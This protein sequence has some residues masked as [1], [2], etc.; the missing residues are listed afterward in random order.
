MPSTRNLAIVA[1]ILCG[2]ATRLFPET[3]NLTAV[4]AVCLFSG[5][6]LQRRWLAVLLPLAAFFV[7]DLIVNARYADQF[8]WSFSGHVYLLFGATVLLGIAIR[9]RPTA[10]RIGTMGVV[11]AA[12]FFVVSNFL[13]WWKGE[14]SEL[15]PN[16]ASGLLACY[17]AGIPFALNMLL[18][19]LLYSA[20]IFGAWYYADQTWPN[21]VEKPAAAVTAS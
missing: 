10:L 8:R 18:G 14:L 20:A 2:V 13:V 11:S 19:N 17:V 7:T 3:L 1:T 21:Q 5:V 4:G 15:Y 12:V 16:T 9:Q 6:Y